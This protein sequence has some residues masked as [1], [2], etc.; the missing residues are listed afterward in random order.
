MA[1]TIKETIVTRVNTPLELRPEAKGESPQKVYDKKKAI[2]RFDQTV[3][4]ILGSIEV[5]LLFRLALK[6]LGAS[7]Q[8]GFTGGVYMLTNPLVAPFRGILGTIV[9]GNTIIEWST[10]ISAAVYLCIAWGLVYLID[11]VYPISPNDVEN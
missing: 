7:P 10:V 3:W 6:A 11:L 1:N 4:Y 9:S 5:L 8:A 2:I